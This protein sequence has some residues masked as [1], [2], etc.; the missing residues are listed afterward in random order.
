MDVERFE[1]APGSPVEIE[2]RGDLTLLGYE[3][4]ALL[5]EPTSRGSVRHE[6]REGK[7][8]LRLVGD[9]RLQL[10]RTA[11]VSVRDLDGD[12]TVRGLQGPL[13]VEHGAGDV[14][15]S[16]VG[17]VHLGSVDGDVSI[18]SAK[19]VLS[20]AYVRGDVVLREVGRTELQEVGEDLTVRDAASLQAIH[21]GGDLTATGVSGTVSL[22][23]VHGDAVLQNIAGPV[24]IGLVAGDLVARD[25]RGDLLV[26]RVDGDASLH[27]PFQEGRQ[28]RV[29]AE[30]D[31][32]VR[33]PEGTSARFFLQAHSWELPRAGS[34]RVETQE[35]GR[36]VVQVGEGGPDVHLASDSEVALASLASN[37]EQTFEDFTRQMERWAEELRRKLEQADWQKVGREV[38]EAT[39]RIAQVVESRLREIDLE[40]IGEGVHE[41]AERAKSVDW[42]KIGRKV[43]RAARQSAEWV[44]ASL[45]RL[46]ERLQQQSS[47]AAETPAS[48]PH[49][50]PVRDDERMAVLR[51]LEEGRLTAEEAAALLDALER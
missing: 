27:I 51:M 35:E 49:E 34:F 36:V 44:Q 39:A 21:V 32:T 4:P 5:V 1:L 8:I 7:H 12:L 15:L 3:D 46:Q 23:Q 11:A 29:S 2:G 22:R 19:Q 30:G 10:W 18:A 33:Y 13:T 25:L 41:A 47:Q 17:E 43:E 14:V 50:G 38:E 24:E 45:R 16:E 9:A 40:R 20:T 48:Q 28:Y 37:W 31:I 42:E 6:E 26:V